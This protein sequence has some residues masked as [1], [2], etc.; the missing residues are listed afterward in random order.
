MTSQEKHQIATMRGRG[1]SY[2]T[3]AAAL[4]V[5][6]NTVKS[7][8]RRNNLGN[9][10]SDVCRHCG[11]PLHHLEHRRP[12]TFCS[13]TCRTSWW[14]ENAA[15]ENRKAVYSFV[16]LTCGKEFT[17]YGNAHRKYCSRACYGF[18]RRGGDE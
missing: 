1:E 8:C 5:L 14:F 12:K 6:E 10:N 17:A 16:C 9:L 2:S 11:R 7:Y 18:S 15:Q 3:I 13:N 4:N